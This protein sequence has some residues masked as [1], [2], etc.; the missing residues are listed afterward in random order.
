MDENF[1]YFLEKM[2]PP[3]EKRHVPP[4]SIERYRGHLPNQLLAYWEEHGWCGYADG[5]FWTVDP[6]EYEPVL[7]AW[8][9]DTQFMEKDAYHVI[10]RS[11]FGELYFWGE[12]SGDSLRILPWY[13]LAFPL[14]GA[15]KYI[16]AGKADD[17]IRW[18]FGGLK[19]KYFDLVDDRERPLF[20]P[21]LEKLGRLKVDEMYAF[22]P[23]LALGGS[24]T[25]AQL[26]KV[27][28]IE[29]LLVLAQLSPLRIMT[30]PIT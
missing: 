6:Q 8:I 15:E 24:A 18:F 1:E 11:A 4:S 2:G 30:S 20:V 13:A 23:A 16:S 14:T 3:V 7:E 17:A 19:R 29:Q 5:L 21:A 27:K 12:K 22:V 9:G 10:A 26:Q 25:L 28:I